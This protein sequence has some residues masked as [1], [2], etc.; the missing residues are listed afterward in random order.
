LPGGITPDFTFSEGGVSGMFFKVTK[1]GPDRQRPEC[2]RLR[3]GSQS[4]GR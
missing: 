2:A 1:R 4:L 3:L